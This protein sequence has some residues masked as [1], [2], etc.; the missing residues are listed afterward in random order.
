M[1]L[2]LACALAAQAAIAL[3]NARL[4]DELVAAER[5]AAAGRIARGLTGL[6]RWQWLDDSRAQTQS[7]YDVLAGLAMRPTGGDAVGLL[8]SYRL[9]D[10][11]RPLPMFAPLSVHQRESRKALVIG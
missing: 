1:E 6:L 4:T 5:D 8:L 9:N 11:T 2:D 3:R 7:G 10:S